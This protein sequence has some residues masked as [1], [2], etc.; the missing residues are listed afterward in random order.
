MERMNI[1]KGKKGF[2]LTLDLIL[3]MVIVFIILGASL[4]FIAKGS[5]TTIAEHQ[6]FRFGSDLVTVLDNQK[7]FDSFNHEFIGVE[8]EKLLPPH[9]QML[10]R[11]EGNF[12]AGN[13]TIEVGGELPPQ[14]SLISGK[15]V[16][17]TDGNEYFKITYYTWVRDNE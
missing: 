12:S 11:I 14:Q 15:K 9:Y 13:G 6:L 3:G 4:F 5:E 10:L 2:V 1:K 17:I 7:V 16:C 8:I